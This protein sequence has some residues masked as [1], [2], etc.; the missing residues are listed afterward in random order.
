MHHYTR[1]HVMI[2]CQFRLAYM[3]RRTRLHNYGMFEKVNHKKRNITPAVVRV[4]DCV[5]GG[6]VLIIIDRPRRHDTV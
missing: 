5:S 1:F 3:P 6:R 2:A 4:V